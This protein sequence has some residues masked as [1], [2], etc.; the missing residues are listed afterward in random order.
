VSRERPAAVAGRFYPADPA[1]LAAVVDAALGAVEPLA[2]EPVPKAL[3]VPHA[4]YVYSGPVA[5]SAYARLL[6]HRERIR[7]IVLLGP[8]HFVP[9]AG[10]AVSGADAFRTPLGAVAVDGGLRCRVLELPQV[11][12]DDHAH[13]R[14]HCL[15]VQLPFLQRVLDRF[16][17]LPL[18]AGRATPSEIADVLARAGDAKDTLLVISSDLS[19]YHD[20]ATAAGRDRRTAA[21]IVARDVDGIDAEDACGS[22]AVRGMIALA[23][24]RDLAV[25]LLDLRSS[26]DTAGPRDEVVGYGAFAFVRAPEVGPTA[27]DSPQDPQPAGGW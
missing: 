3:I 12:I 14:E 20:Y 18:L 19:H 2:P 22:A 6:P 25:R 8:A 10:L 26:G 24:K 7:R 23:R 16:T 13:A 5:A 21:A 4:G 9:V 11:E 17:I 1:E 27:P 15:E